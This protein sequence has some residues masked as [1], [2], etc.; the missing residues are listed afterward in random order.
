MTRDFRHQIF[1][2][3]SVSPGPLSIPLGPFQIFSKILGDIREWMCISGVNDTGE[4]R[5]KFWNTIFLHICWEL[6]LVHFTPKDWIFAYFYFLGVGK[7]ILAGLFNCRCRWHRRMIYRR[8]RWHRWTV[9]RRCRLQ[10]RKILGFLVISRWQGLI[11]GVNDT[12]DKFFAGVVDTAEQFIAGVNDTGARCH[13]FCFIFTLIEHTIFI[14]TTRRAPVVLSSLHPLCRGPPL[15]VPSRYSN[16]GLL[17]SKPMRYNLSHT[18][19]WSLIMYFMYF[20]FIIILG[21][22][23][24]LEVFLIQ[25][26]GKHAF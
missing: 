6:S 14:Y 8:C 12:G 22:C 20:S 11:A 3:K 2:H 19:P 16:S 10:R 7:L 15:G 18:A 4:K 21:V 5:E 26:K 17:Y 1:F 23:F 9:F 25:G 13:S 24:V